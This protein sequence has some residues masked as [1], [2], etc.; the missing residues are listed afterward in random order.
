MHRLIMTTSWMIESYAH[1]RAERGAASRK[2]FASSN[3]HGKHVTD[4]KSAVR[5]RLP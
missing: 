1:I 2:S 5:W 3:S 4:S